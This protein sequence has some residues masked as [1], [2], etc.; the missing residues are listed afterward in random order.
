MAKTLLFTATA[1]TLV[2]G[3][4][5]NTFDIS[6]PTAFKSLRVEFTLSSDYAYLQIQNYDADGWIDFLDENGNPLKLD[7]QFRDLVIPAEVGTY[8]LRGIIAGTLK[9]WT[10]EV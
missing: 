2:P 8:A 7:A 1:E 5:G 9:A 3:S 10:S 4:S 6:D